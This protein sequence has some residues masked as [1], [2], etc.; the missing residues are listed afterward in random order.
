[1]RDVE[2][3]MRK[4]REAKLPLGPHGYV[5]AAA[6]EKYRHGETAAPR[7]NMRALGESMKKRPDEAAGRGS[8]GDWERDLVEGARGEDGCAL[9][10]TAER[11]ARRDVMRL[12]PGKGPS[13]C[14]SRRCIRLCRIRGRRIFLAP[15]FKL[16]E[17]RC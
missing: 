16:G 7:K 6:S 14:K 2:R 9:F 4:P 3:R 13:G 5:G 17:R 10:V 15:L 11:K 1:V 8:H 12:L